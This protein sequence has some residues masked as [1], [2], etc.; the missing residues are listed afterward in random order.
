MTDLNKE[1]VSK[2]KTVDMELVG[3]TEKDSNEEAIQMMGLLGDIFGNTTEKTVRAMNNKSKLDNVAIF[4]DY[5][6]VYWTLENN[7]K[8]NPDSDDSAKN[9]FVQLWERYKQ[10]N[11]RTFRAY[12]DFQKIKTSLTSLQKKRVQIRHVYS[13]EKQGDHRKNSS[14]IELCIDAIESTYK[15]PN[16]S[17]YVF[18]TADSDM[19]PILSRLMYKGKRVELFYLS[20]ALPKHIDMTTYAHYSQDLL[21]FINIEDNVIDIENYIYAAIL[22]I[23]NW[24]DQFKNTDKFLGVSWLRNSLSTELRIPPND[25]SALI[26]KLRTENL[27]DDEAKILS[28]GTSKSSI[29]LTENSLQRISL[30]EVAATY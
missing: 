15:D 19:I 20:K 13:N 23:Q 16:I 12:A 7:Y 24:Q 17:C 9:L 27:I 26:E 1:I 11:V 29:I 3:Y 6:N 28:N 5:D 22:F 2:E 30:V 8:H 25:C 4:V 21:E 14:D 10:D 18:V